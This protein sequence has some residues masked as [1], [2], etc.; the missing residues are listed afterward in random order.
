MGITV[1]VDNV[2]SPYHLEPAINYSTFVFANASK[3][4]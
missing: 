1:Y 2:I 4:V 3:S